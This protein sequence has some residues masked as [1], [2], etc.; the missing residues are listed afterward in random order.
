MGLQNGNERSS[1][2]KCPFQAGEY[3]HRTT[4]NI[5]R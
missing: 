5:P 3:S 1:K 4:A 2:M